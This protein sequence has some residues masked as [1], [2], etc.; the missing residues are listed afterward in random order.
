L[1]YYRPL[2][3][4]DSDDDSDLSGKSASTR[5]AWGYASG[6]GYDLSGDDVTTGTDE[7]SLQL[8]VNE[9]SSA[10]GTV[11]ITESAHSGSVEFDTSFKL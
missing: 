1:K 6:D 2:A 8:T 10:I 11:S 7:K 3:A 9:G 5:M 4:G